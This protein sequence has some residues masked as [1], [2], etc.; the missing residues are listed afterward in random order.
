ME[1]AVGDDPLATAVD[2]VEV[3]VPFV[4][5]SFAAPFVSGALTALG[6]VMGIADFCTVLEAIALARAR[7]CGDLEA[8]IISHFISWFCQ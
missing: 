6:F 8:R 5:P 2:D 7:W 4:S 3:G 1:L